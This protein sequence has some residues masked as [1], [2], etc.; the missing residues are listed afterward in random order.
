MSVV[1]RMGL[2]A[3]ATHDIDGL[4]ATGNQAVATLTWVS[5]IV[6]SCSADRDGIHP[7]DVVPPNLR[8][9][10]RQEFP[11]ARCLLDSRGRGVQPLHLVSGGALRPS[12]HGG[13]SRSDLSDHV[14]GLG[15]VL[16]VV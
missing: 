4:I 1:A 15:G 11:P 8:T 9:D 16:V 12:T 13:R 5:G 14:R 2:N 7:L 6:C 3:Q 10:A